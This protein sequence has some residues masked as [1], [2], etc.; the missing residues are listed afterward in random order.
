MTLKGV[1]MK[2]ILLVVIG[3]VI[4]VLAML[5]TYAQTSAALTS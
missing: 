4:G 5:L 2:K 1:D 3:I